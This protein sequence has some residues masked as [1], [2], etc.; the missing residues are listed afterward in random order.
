MAKP[1]IVGIVS[2]KGGVGKSTLCQLIAREAATGGKHAKIL[3]FDTISANAMMST[4]RI[5]VYCYG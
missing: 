3:D 1:K 2:Q 4:E 5:K